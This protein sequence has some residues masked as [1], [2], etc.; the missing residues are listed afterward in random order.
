MNE[1]M[2]K[3]PMY[4]QLQDLQGKMAPF[5]QRYQ[6]QQMQQMQ[7]MQRPSPFRRGQF[8][9]PAGLQGLMGMLGGRGRTVMPQAQPR[10]SMDMP[11]TYRHMEALP[12]N[13]MKKGGKV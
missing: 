9:Q 1:Y 3:A 4:Q 13:F 7:Q 5:Q 11:Q 2:Q 10:M 8:Q 6:Q 12:Q